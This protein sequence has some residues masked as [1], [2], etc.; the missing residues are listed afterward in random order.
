M[1]SLILIFLF[2][3][4]QLGTLA[5]TAHYKNTLIVVGLMARIKGYFDQL[6]ITVTNKTDIS[7]SIEALDF[8]TSLSML[9]VDPYKK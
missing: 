1:R 6:S 7:R 4:Q 5:V 2:F 3:I 8:Q 9:W